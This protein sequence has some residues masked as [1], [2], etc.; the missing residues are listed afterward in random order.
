MDNTRLGAYSALI[1]V[2]GADRENLIE[3]INRYEVIIKGL[4]EEMNKL[5]RQGDEMCILLERRVVNGGDRV[6]AINAWKG[7]S[8][9]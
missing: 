7:R 8:Q 6:R 2:F 5:D 4:Q 9:G 1:E 3:K